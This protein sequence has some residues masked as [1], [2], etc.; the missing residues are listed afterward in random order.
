MTTLEALVEEVASR[1]S[2]AGIADARL[3]AMILIEGLTGLTQLDYLVTG[4]KK[5]DERRTLRVRQA[6]ER[7]VTGEPVYRILGAREFYGRKFSLSSETLEPRP[8]SEILVDAALHVLRSRH[9]DRWRILDMGTGSGVIAITLLNEIEHAVATAVDISA[10]AL[11]TA[12]INA[13]SLGVGQRFIP[14][15]S[16]WFSAVSG[17]Y[18]L[19]VSNPPYIKTADITSLMPE[20]KNHDPLRALDGGEDGLDFFRLLATQS[21]NYLARDGTILVEIGIGQGDDVSAIFYEAGY[22]LKDQRNDLNGLLRVVSFVRRR[23]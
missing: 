19:I 12:V 18:D 23:A 9:L 11:T 13:S 10:Q 1:L 4:T 3:E 16:D 20:V 2:A 5:V 17:N 8:D 6:V 22:E 15:K 21:A 7:R 14:V